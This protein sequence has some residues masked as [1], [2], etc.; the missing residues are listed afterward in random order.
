M[1]GGPRGILGD[2]GVFIDQAAETHVR[3]MVGV[4][5]VEVGSGRGERVV[6]GQGPLGAMAVEVIFVDVENGLQMA[7]GEDQ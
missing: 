6:A 3:R 5:L 4:S 7:R 2:V 1:D